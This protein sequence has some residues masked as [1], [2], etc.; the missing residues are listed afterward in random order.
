MASE[1]NNRPTIDQVREYWDSHPLLSYELRDVGSKSFFENFDRC[2]RHDV[3]RFSFGFWEF[4]VFAGKSVLDVGCGP[5]WITVMYAKGGADVTAVDLTPAAVA[6]TSTHLEQLGLSAIVREANAEELPFPD[7]SFDLVVSSGVLHHTPNY[8]RAISECLRVL[9]PGGKAKL[10]FYRKGVLHHPLI[11]PLTRTIMRL[12]GVKHPGANLA[13]TST[14]VDDFIRQY[15]GESNPVGIGMPNRQWVK[16]LE[17]IGFKVIDWENHY[18]PVRF[19]PFAGRVPKSLHR[20]LDSWFGS[21]IY[22]R[23]TKP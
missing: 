20:L 16:L 23:L 8:R 5:G 18:F 13:S 22:C 21:M 17:E 6:L 11:W 19:L 9:R 7:N 3:E 15:D 1:T 2:K 10:T 12:A 4:P 14:D